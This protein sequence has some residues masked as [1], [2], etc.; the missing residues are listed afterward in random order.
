MDTGFAT[1]TGRVRRMNQDAAGVWLRQE[2]ASRA[3]GLFVV[4]D[5]MGG[6]AGGEVASRI[7]VDTVAATVAGCLEELQA[8]AI[9]EFLVRTLHKALEA[10]NEAVWRR[11]TQ[12]PEFQ[13]MG[14]TCVAA[15][16][17]GHVAAVGNVGDSRVYRLRQGVLTQITCD[18]SLVQDYV[19]AG[20]L[21]P[22]EARVSRFRNVITRVIG[23]A[24][25]VQPDVD[26]VDLAPG[27][28]LL[29]CTDGLSTMLT[30]PQIAR[31]LAAAPSAQEAADRLVASANLQ[32]GADNITVI[33][34]HFGPFEPVVLP[35]NLDEDASYVPPLDV[36]AA[37]PRSS[38]RR[39]PT[40]FLVLVAIL[41][42][43]TAYLF[44]RG[45]LIPPPVPVQPL[46]ENAGAVQEAAVEYGPPE[47][48]TSKPVQGA[49]LA[50]DTSGNI[51][52]LSLSGRILRISRA[53]GPTPDFGPPDPRAAKASPAPQYWAVD[54]R[55]FLYVSDRYARRVHKYDPSGT[56]VAEIGVGSLN[57]PQGIAVDGAGNV[58]VVDGHILKVLRPRPLAPRIGPV[59]A[60]G[61]SYAPR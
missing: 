56:R 40:S 57:D 46:K 54:A 3:D 15:L 38:H 44:L 2:L 20:E 53:E 8:E 58:Y 13:G 41:S 35:P 39:G 43:V 18:H 12:D 33:V 11:A 32:G 34:V 61:K 23:G 24:P 9:P 31:I 36:L 50:C 42:A 14:T 49:P 4:A 7:A 51:Y 26:L 28:A 48:V 52:A 55:G 47:I 25:T 5:G 19:N 16:I 1:D 60:A 22:A 29:L 30:D 45:F 27:D 21:S 37:A 59:P 10:A 17:V 6:R